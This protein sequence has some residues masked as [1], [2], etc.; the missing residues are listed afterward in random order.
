[1]PAFIDDDKVPEWLF[2]YDD[3]HGAVVR[4]YTYVHD[5]IVELG[6]FG[7]LEAMLYTEYE[8]MK[9]EQMK[10]D[11]VANVS[12]DIKTPLTSIISY[13][14]LLKQEADLPE[15]VKEFIR[16]L[17]EKSERLRTIVQDVF[18]ISKATS[19]QLPVTID[20]LDLRIQSGLF[21]MKM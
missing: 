5:R 17:G 12:H 9:S 15:H 20:E 19:G 14:E 8:G 10:V 13:I 6:E 3:N 16:I 18:E 4:A 11:L 2:F 1:M 7:S 21:W